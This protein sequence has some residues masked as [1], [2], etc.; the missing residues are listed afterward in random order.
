MSDCILY[1]ARLGLRG[2]WLR[3]PDFVL[4]TSSHHEDIIASV[5]RRLLFAGIANL[6]TFSQR[7][8]SPFQSRDL[9][10]I[11]TQLGMQAEQCLVHLFEIMLRMSQRRFETDQSLIGRCRGH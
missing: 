11:A 4:T 7:H 1:F 2:M 5:V 3:E 6:R 8:Q 10:T 9:L